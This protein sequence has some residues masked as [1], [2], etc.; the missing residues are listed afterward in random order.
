MIETLSGR[1]V[2]TPG[3]AQPYK[4]VVEDRRGGT[5]EFP[6]AS[7]NEGEALMREKGAVVCDRPPDDWHV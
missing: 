7:I 5:S 6:V 3:E 4:L 2:R 1:I